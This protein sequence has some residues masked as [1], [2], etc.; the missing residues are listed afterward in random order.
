MAVIVQ[1]KANSRVRTGPGNPGKTLNLKNKNP[2]L[3]SRGILLKV[4]KSPGIS[5]NEKRDCK[6]SICSSLTAPFSITTRHTVSNA[7]LCTLK[8]SLKNLIRSLKTPGIVFLH[9][10]MNP[11]ISINCLLV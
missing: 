9:G 11:V 6:N 10:S 4:L 1:W 5:S 2:G 8:R 7:K 3:E